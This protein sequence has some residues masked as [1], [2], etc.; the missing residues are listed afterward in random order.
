[1]VCAAHLYKIW[2][3][4]VRQI[5]RGETY[6]VFVA[7]WLDNLFEY[8]ICLDA[9][10]LQRATI[11]VYNLYF[12]F[13]KIYNTISLEIWLLTTIWPQ[14]HFLSFDLAGW[15]PKFVLTWSV[16]KFWPLLSSYCSFHLPLGAVAN[17]PI[18][19]QRKFLRILMPTIF[20]R[21]RASSF[22]KEFIYC[23]Y[24][25]ILPAVVIDFTSPK[26]QCWYITKISW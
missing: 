3:T 2:R 26:I 14:Q 24:K 12:L 23:F 8:G 4:T 6:G 21:L 13:V 22:F 7:N 10:P 11:N 17:E 9:V 25:I 18:W 20:D 19:P 5:L 15:F 16:N 1:M